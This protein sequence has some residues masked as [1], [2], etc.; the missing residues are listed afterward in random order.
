MVISF[1]MGIN[2]NCKVGYGSVSKITKSYLIQWYK[3]GN[4]AI[5]SLELAE[6][7][8]TACTF[9]IACIVGFSSSLTG[10][11]GV[12]PS[13]TLAAYANKYMYFDLCSGFS[14]LPDLKSASTRSSVIKRAGTHYTYLFILC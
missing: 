2:L 4:S 7:Q 12:V 11:V 13:H 9:S 5:N 6:L 14:L 8:Q 1:C 10:L 3:V